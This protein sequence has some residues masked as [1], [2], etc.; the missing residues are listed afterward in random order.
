MKSTAQSEHGEAVILAKKLVA[1]YR[2]R[3]WSEEDIVADLTSLAEGEPV[4]RRELISLLA[5]G[6]GIPLNVLCQEIGVGPAVVMS[7]RRKD[8]VL[9]Q[10]VRDY[11]GAYF[12]DEAQ[13][14]MKDI[15]SGV[16]LGGL[17]SFAHGWK[18]GEGRTLTDED[19]Q[20]I[21]RAII[22]SVRLR[23]S[24][25]NVLKAIGE[26]ISQTLSRFQQGQ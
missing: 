21:I 15:K 25:P 1:R 19:L 22:D 6:S 23:V 5:V 10:A 8:P 16:L 2:D 12:E 26:D 7:R 17:N 24:D 3:E 14:P 4:W 11:L 20:R 18:E 9:D 13:I